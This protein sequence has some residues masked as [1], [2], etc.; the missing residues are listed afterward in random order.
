MNEI[1]IKNKLIS[2]SN[3]MLVSFAILTCLT[4]CNTTKHNIFAPNKKLFKMLPPGPPAFQQGWLDGCETGLAT[5]FANDYYKTFYKFKKDINMV[6]NKVTLYTRAW[7]SAMIYCRHYATGTLKEA[8]MTPK[9]A[10][11]EKPMTLGEHSIFGG[12]FSLQNQ[13][14]VGLKNW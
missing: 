10:G 14:S 2:Y 7:S 8:G 1:S 4:N 12:P 9:L 3:I 13:G 6:K 11:K 5:G